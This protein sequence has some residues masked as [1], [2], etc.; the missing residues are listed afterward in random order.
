MR[1]RAREVIEQSLL[2]LTE[3]SPREAGILM[4]EGVGSLVVDRRP[5]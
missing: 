4:R 1:E 3:L 2:R 5:R